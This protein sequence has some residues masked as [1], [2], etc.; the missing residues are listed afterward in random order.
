M[1]TVVE[2]ADLCRFTSGGTP[3]KARP[4]YW[5]GTTPWVSSADI[6]ESSDTPEVSRFVTDAGIA[7]SATKPVPAGTV[8]LVTRV[9]V[10]KVAIADRQMA[11][12]QDIVGLHPDTSRVETR[13][14]WHFLRA[15]GPHLAEKARGATIQ[16]IKRADFD[17]L[18]V[19]VLPLP[20]QRRTAALLDKADALIAKRQDAIALI[21]ELEHSVFLEM[22][23]R[24]D[25]WDSERGEVTLEAVLDPEK[26]AIRTGPFG[27]QLLHSEFTDSGVAV[28]GIDNA[29]QNRF[30]WGQPRFIS[31]QK[32]QQL[33]RYRVKPG[34]V[35]ITIM[36]TCGRAAI[37][38]PDI[39][40]AINTKHLCCI[41]L[42]RQWC[43]PEYLHAYFLRHPVAQ[44]YLRGRAK[45]AIMSGLNMSIIREM[46]LRA[47]PISM[48]REYAYRVGALHA[49]KQRLAASLDV[50]HEGKS[51]LTNHVFGDV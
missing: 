34:D 22:F 42:D 41:T 47:P 39:P 32:Y 48:Q 31:E 16:G 1:T 25:G 30:A 4:E 6:T 26:G 28:L 51:T 43:L 10:G 9:G 15:A 17:N 20:E 19:P 5:G 14:L 3:S 23:A 29:V 37:V 45:G 13:Y 24:N 18:P 44:E 2:L 40:T 50:L 49:S 33:A 36:G 46:P 12:S 8:L 11:F 38:P 35:L 7:N 27:S 21:D